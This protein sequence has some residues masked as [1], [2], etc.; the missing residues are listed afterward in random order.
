MDSATFKGGGL[1]AL[2]ALLAMGAG[3]RSWGL[4]IAKV[5]GESRASPT[6]ARTHG[7]PPGCADLAPPGQQ[8]QQITVDPTHGSDSFEHLPFELRLETPPDTDSL[9]WRANVGIDAAVAIMGHASE[10]HRFEAERFQGADLPG[11][12][13]GLEQLQLCYDWE[14][15]VN[16]D[17]NTAL[18]RTHRWTIEHTGPPAHLQPPPHGQMDSVLEFSVTKHPARR[19]K[20]RVSGTITIDNLTPHDAVLTSVIDRTDDAHRSVVDCGRPVA[21]HVLEAGQTLTCTYVTRLPDTLPRLGRTVVTTRGEVGGASHETAIDFTHA[22]VTTVH[23]TVRVRATTGQSWI[24]TDSTTTT[25]RHAYRCPDQAGRH[26]SSV[27]IVETEES[28]EAVVT[29]EC[30]RHANRRPSPH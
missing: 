16:K 29:V 11:P 25:Y 13:E 14:L 18:T 30:S 3:V 21:G 6:N 22:A 8:W 12:S 4:A 17:A 10:V 20:W 26:Q 9:T 15:T 23:D 5:P 28:S 19:S 7:G 27:A 1:L 2:V 24:F